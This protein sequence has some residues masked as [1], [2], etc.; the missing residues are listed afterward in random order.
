[1]TQLLTLPTC[2]LESSCTH[3]ALHDPPTPES[4]SADC[5]TRLQQQMHV[6]TLSWTVTDRLLCAFSEKKKSSVSWCWGV[7][8]CVGA[9]Q[10]HCL[11]FCNTALPQRPVTEWWLLGLTKHPTCFICVSKWFFF[12]NFLGLNLAAPEVSNVCAFFFNQVTATLTSTENEYN[13]IFKKVSRLHC[14]KKKPS[15]RNKQNC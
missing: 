14:T 11:F 12:L 13:R 2:T 15:E 1:M 10:R 3:A 5:M 4:K 9:F 6:N 7:C 8:M